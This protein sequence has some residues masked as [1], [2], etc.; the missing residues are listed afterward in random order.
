MKRLWKGILVCF[1]LV[2]LCGCG[3][4]ENESPIIKLQGKDIKVGE[5]EVREIAL[6]DEIKIKTGL[7]GM[8]EP[9][10][11]INANLYKGEDI[12]ASVAISNLSNEDVTEY[13]CIIEEISIFGASDE[14]KSNYSFEFDGVNL[15]GAN[16]EALTPVLKEFER[17]EDNGKV[18]FYRYEGSYSFRIV[19]ENDVVEEIHLSHKF[20]R[21]FETK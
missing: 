11:W 2:G 16:E 18:T 5:T 10:T 21:S 14:D 15:I 4:A 3:E 8:M 6:D 1:M 17:E 19:L 7:I 9:N 12:F 20:N 13:G